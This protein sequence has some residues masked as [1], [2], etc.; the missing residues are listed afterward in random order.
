MNHFCHPPFQVALPGLRFV[1]PPH[2]EITG[3]EYDTEQGRFAF[4][5]PSGPAGQYSFRPVPG[6][7]DMKR[8][9]E[10]IHRRHKGSDTVIPL[11][12]ENTASGILLATAEKGERF[13]ASCYEKERK[14]LHEWIFST[15][16]PETEAD[17]RLLLESVCTNPPDGEGYSFYALF[18]LEAWLPDG[19]ELT[20]IRP[21]PAD[22]T[23]EFEN[24][25]HHRIILSR[26]G[27]AAFHLQNDTL[28]RFYQERLVRRKYTV[29]KLGERLCGASSLVS[30]EFR[31]RG[32]FGFDA[33]LGPWW[34]GVGEAFLLRSANRIYT[35]EHIAPARIPQ[36]EKCEKIF[37]SLL[38]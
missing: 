20:E 16:T 31:V 23:L 34:K 22:V 29:K 36:R 8:I 26:I 37:R 19:F 33:L 32:R 17:A 5:L 21:Y 3:Y 11:Q 7:P 30:H 13:Y 38:P 14:R 4:S 6:D 35:F 27:M 12:F 2:W 28:S 1:L 9:W 10:E 15:R 24:R 18:G 25:K